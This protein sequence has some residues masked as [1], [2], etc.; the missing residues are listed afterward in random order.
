MLRKCLIEEDCQ[1][2]KVGLKE[3]ESL[4]KAFVLFLKR[5][6]CLLSLELSDQPFKRCSH[7]VEVD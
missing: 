2:T 7:G 5:E 1:N 4:L 3:S 6:L